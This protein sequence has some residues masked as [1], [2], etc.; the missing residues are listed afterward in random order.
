M[1]SGTSVPHVCVTQRHITTSN[2]GGAKTLALFH[3]QPDVKDAGESCHR[4]GRIEIVG[5]IIE[6]ICK[7]EWENWI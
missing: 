1:Q 6:I 5:G 3:N 4:F 7:A 2:D